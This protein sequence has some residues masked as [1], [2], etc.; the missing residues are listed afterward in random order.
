M[1]LGQPQYSHSSAS[2][3][4]LLTD[5][6]AAN[7]PAFGDFLELGKARL[8]A[9]VVLTTLTGYLLASVGPI[10]LIHLLTTLLGTALAAFGANAF[11]QIIEAPR[12][13]RMHRTRNRPLPA[14]RLSTWQALAFAAACSIGGPG[15]LTAFI[16]PIAGCLA[17]ICLVIYVTAYTP[18]KPRTSLN[19]LV[20]GICGAIPP[21]IG[22]A[23]ITGGL[24]PGAWI[25]G[26]IL[27]LWQM[28][29]FLALAWLYR[30]DYERGGFVMLPHVDPRGS[31]TGRC[32]VLFS[33]SLI[34]ATLMLTIAGITGLYYAGGALL[35]GLAASW[36][37]LKLY[38][39]RSASDA[40]RVFLASV[41]YLPILLALMVADRTAPRSHFE[42]TP[43]V[44]VGLSR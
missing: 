28:P 32:V 35:M 20:G 10:S 21:M 15:L 4:V 11:N 16:N 34:P 38:H 2:A 19:T 36:L 39:S 14:N 40:R 41:I 30:E 37:G 42:A 44:V 1:P 33:I 13:L 23:A 5:L 27:F 12:D 17:L 43:T 8:S 6:P 31:L 24:E 9:L 29:H 18:L 25:L 7:W 26:M 22:W 3:D